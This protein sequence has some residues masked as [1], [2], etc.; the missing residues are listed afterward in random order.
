MPFASCSSFSP[1]HLLQ[2]VSDGKFGFSHAFTCYPA[3]AK[4]DEGYLA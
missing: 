4:Y 3:F 1:W 2:E